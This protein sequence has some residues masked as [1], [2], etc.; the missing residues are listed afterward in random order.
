MK[1]GLRTSLIPSINLS[2]MSEFSLVIA[3]LGLGLKHIGGEVVGILTFVFAITSVLS[4]YLIQYNNGIHLRFAPFLKRLGLTDINS[5]ISAAEE[6]ELPKEI[7]FLGFFWETSSIFHEIETLQAESAKSLTEKILVV[8]FNPLVYAELNKREAKCVYGDI[9]SVDTRKHAHADQTRTAVCTIPD[10]VLRETTNVRLLSLAKRLCAHAQV[11]VPACTI[12]KALGFYR[13]GAN[14][15]FI[16]RIHSSKVIAGIISKSLTQSLELYREED[17][18]HLA[19][20][21]EV[22]G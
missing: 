5:Q 15:V 13:N 22:I 2:Q 7:V 21:R 9:S 11:I 19:N 12:H 1:N 18:A 20:C 6:P 14:F 4:T 16:P 17:I 3:A 8:D 10:S